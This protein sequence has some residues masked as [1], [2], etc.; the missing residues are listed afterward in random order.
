MV[1]DQR[2]AT[3]VDSFDLLL[4]SDVVRLLGCSRRMSVFSL[5]VFF[6][7]QMYKQ[8]QQHVFQACIQ[9]IGELGWRHWETSF[10]RNLGPVSIEV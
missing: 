7:E 5:L 4:T 3:L 8:W 2:M 10:G 6:G 1:G 9:G